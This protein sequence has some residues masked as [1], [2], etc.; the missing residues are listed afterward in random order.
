MMMMMIIHFIATIVRH[1]ILPSIQNDAEPLS[2]V[3]RCAI[4]K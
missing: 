4:F 3:S 2:A 1:Y